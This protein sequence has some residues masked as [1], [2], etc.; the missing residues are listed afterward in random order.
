[1]EI[2]AAGIA[3]DEAKLKTVL[4]NP[5]KSARIVNLVYV[6]DNI[7]GIT[8]VRRGKSFHYLDGQTKVSDPRQLNRIKKL[9]IPPAWEQV[10]ICKDGRGHIQVTGLDTRKRKQYRYHPLWNVV[11][12][13]T[14]FYR[15]LEFGRQLPVMRAKIEAHLAEKEFSR[16]KVLALVV[17]ILEKT[18]IRVGNQEYEKSYGSF[19]LTTLKN[20]HAAINGNT[21]TFSF[22]S[23]KGIQQNIS[24]RSRKL[25]RMVKSCQDIPGRE[26]FEYIDELGVHNVDS[27]M[28]NDYIR[29]LSGCD[30]TAKD[31]RTWEGSLLAIKS[32]MGVGGFDTEAEMKRNVL[33]ALDDVAKGLGNTRTVCRKYYVH[34]LILQRYEEGRLQEYFGKDTQGSADTNLA[35]RILISL[36]EDH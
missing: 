6:R 4:D 19:G 9:V 2:A 27:G 30:F 23:K 28:V 15:L 31:F 20:R 36:L 22:K 35:E 33:S 11:R 8:R 17:S 14:K 16:N 13:Q 24:L 5:E 7:P 26:L 29:E 18:G 32:L 12:S 25:A 34:P 21:V 1:M 3:I 10:W